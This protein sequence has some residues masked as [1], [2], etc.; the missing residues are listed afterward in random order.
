MTTLN[1]L[2]LNIRTFSSSTTTTTTTTTIGYG[3]GG[4]QQIT[5]NI[6]EQ[7]IIDMRSDTVTKP[8]PDMLHAMQH[9]AVG[10]DVFREDPTVLELETTAATLL[11]KES[12]LFVPSG[13]MGNLLGILSH[14]NGAF[15]SEMIVGD[16]QHTY[17][18]EQGNTASIGGV[19][20]CVIPNQDN[21]T[22]K[23]EDIA[24]SIRC[25]D[26]HYPATKLV[27]LENTHNMCGGVP[28]PLGY[29]DDVGALT[30]EKGIAL[31]VDGAR[32]CN[33]SAA[34]GVPLDVLC[35]AVDSVSVCLSKGLGSPVGSILVGNTEFIT[36]ARR[37]RKALGGGM[38]QAGVLAS[39]G[40]ISLNVMRHRLIVDHARLNML[41]EG[42]VQLGPHIQPTGRGGDGAVLTTN[43]GFY[44]IANNRAAELVEELRVK[45]GVLISAKDETTIRVV[46]HHHIGNDE[47]TSVI[48]AF[49]DV[50]KDW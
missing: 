32:I 26:P 33:A 8:T 34:L 22:L 16:R 18:Y 20:S 4:G 42:L 24:S 38:R 11:G 46:T 29:M 43:L 19:H 48:A 9:A 49:E 27:S 3:S 17:L 6:S 2:R 28:L 47:I 39:C 1:L 23:L 35:E 37:Y 5:S 45:H 21:G 12:A 31:H 41:T 15:G 40:L 13:T 25:D 50:V 14:T 36:R 7:T 10:D 44:T 30:K